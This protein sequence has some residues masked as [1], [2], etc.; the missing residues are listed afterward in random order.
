MAEQSGVVESTELRLIA[1]TDRTEML[2]LMR[3]TRV[4]FVGTRCDAV[5]RSIVADSLGRRPKL[6]TVVAERDGE[7]VGFICAVRSDSTR[8]WR[9]FLVRHPM[10]GAA[11]AWT[12]ARKLPRRI[13]YRRRKN[14]L[15]D[16]DLV[17][18]PRVSLPDEVADRLGKRPPS[19]GS[20]RPGE[21]GPTISLVLY[22][23]VDPAARG[24]GL[25]VSLY[26]RMFDELRR[27]GSTRCDCSFSA[28]DP[29]AIR[30]HCTFPFT[31]YRLP[32]G[33]W[34]SLRLED[35]AS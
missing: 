34:A 6:L 24:S 18:T 31:I 20:P 30:M 14:A 28:K 1:P 16:N 21:H 4:H 9:F 27:V 35:L 10:A 19:S 23:L 5:Y 25:G 8:F 17:L 2:D 22:V 32:G 7:L 11:I 13:R 15:Y 12:R 26:R 3:R 33:Y 29:A